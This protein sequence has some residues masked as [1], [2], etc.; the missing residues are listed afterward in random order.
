MP[1]A[2]EERDGRDAGGCG[3]SSE[4][5]DAV[6]RDYAKLI[7]ELSADYAAR[8]PRSAELDRRATRVMVDGGS[9]AVRLNPPFPVRVAAAA[10]AYVRD[11]D[12]HE[13]L[14]FWQ[15]HYANILGHNP[16]I[17]THALA[18]AFAGGDGLQLGMTD[19]VQIEYA[20]FLCRRVHAEA[21][22]F[23]TSGTL[24]TMYAIMLARAFTGR[25][26][27]L[28]V[29]GGWHGSQPWGLHSVHFLPGPRPWAVESEG[30]PAGAAA[31]VAVTRFN[32]PEDLG[33]TFRRLGDR[34]ACFIVEPFAGAGSFIGAA[35]EYLAAAREVTA[36]YGALL[37]LDEVI[38]GF[39]FC[40]GDLGS[41]YGV[42]PD[43]V[44]L[45]K[46]IGGGMPVA[47]VAGRRDVLALS[48]REGGSR[49][50]FVGGT[51][52]AHP[53]SLLAGKKLVS[54]L[55]EHEDEVYP[56]L[57]EL[58]ERVRAAIAQAFGEEDILVR[59]SGEPSAVMPGSS[60][61]G[62]HFP[63]DPATAIDRPHMT[64]DSRFFDAV[65]KER[66]FQLALLLEDAYSLYG[67]CAASTALTE[68][69]VDRL[70]E[71]CRAVARRIRPHLSRD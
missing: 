70:G 41:L 63:Y 53:A 9:H 21:L 55:V 31:E 54:F 44:T 64:R 46:I 16:K 66:V 3:R 68:A 5:E 67:C 51:Y 7:E 49:V 4:R 48:G 37:I 26:L 2:G 6:A 20:E 28:K 36:R 32:D 56:R 60:L 62:V 34:V 61:T 1:V 22:R 42:R 33:A 58:G 65:L 40:A 25:D 12:G 47:A 50:G 59:C 39:R 57:G 29:A 10:G 35:P 27:V 11:V 71:A 43:L 23:T 45:G 17:V 30:L 14:D 18:D 38:S 15:G 13:I 8:F 69:D 24:A 19:E 52:S